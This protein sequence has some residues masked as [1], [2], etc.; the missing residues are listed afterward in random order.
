MKENIMLSIL[1]LSMTLTVLSPK[2]HAAE[3]SMDKMW[4][5]SKIKEVQ[6]DPMRGPHLKEGRFGLFI[7]WGLYSSLAGKWKEKTYYGI[8]EWIMHPAMAGIPISDYMG[9]AKNFNPDQFDAK[10]IVR[11]T[12]DAGMK[13]VIVTSKHH[14]GFAMFKSS[15]PF[16][17]VDGSPFGR[18]PLKELSQACKEEGLGFGL[19]YSHFQDWTEPGAHG[20]PKKNADGSEATFEKYF[21]EKCYPQVKEICSNYGPLEVI[22][23]DTPG[24]MPKQNVI[25]LHDLVRATQPKAL[26]GSRIGYGLGDY[27][28]LGDMEVPPERVDGLWE[29]CDTTNDSWSYAWYDTNW[30]TP[31][32]IIK[33]LVSTV[34]RGGTYLLNVGPNEKGTVPLLCQEALK[35]SGGWIKENSRVIYGAAASPWRYTMPWGDI[36]TQK[37]GTLN[38]VVFDPPYDQAIYLP[39]LKTPVKSV[40]MNQKG[41]KTALAFKKWGE[42]VRV[43]LPEE[44][45]YTQPVLIEVELQGKAVW[46][47][48]LLEA[49]VY[50]VSLKYRGK[51]EDKARITWRIS[52]DEG[53][54][55]QNQQAVTSQYQSYPMGVLRFK[56]PGKHRIEVQ[57]VDGNLSESSLEALELVKA[58]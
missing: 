23:F 45:L 36:T 28:S 6:T 24:D 39:Y 26:L 34:A 17:I 19:Y 13:Y 22:W 51:A 35:E 37:N 8:G 56:N 31:R 7:H 29:S 49:G 46:D 43:Q 21:R 54:S 2:I 20:G 50:Q 9:V 41:K 5:D 53:A 3:Q 1:T 10:A 14:E 42:S 11:M 30:K 15:H 40:F 57:L 44:V 48:N 38:L 25:E 47:I 12:K 18:D 58:R 16:N 4:G 55:V 32:E 52:T 33:R 27:E